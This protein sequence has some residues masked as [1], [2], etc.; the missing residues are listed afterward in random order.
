M[1]PNVRRCTGDERICNFYVRVTQ[2]IQNPINISF[3]KPLIN[4]TYL[5]SSQAEEN[6]SYNS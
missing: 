4:I 3:E 2:T 1:C 5:V 6:T